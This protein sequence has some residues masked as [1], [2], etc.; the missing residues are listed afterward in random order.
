MAYARGIV[1]V[2]GGLYDQPVREM[3]LLAAYAGGFGR[4]MREN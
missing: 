3:L 2:A 1:F 4:G